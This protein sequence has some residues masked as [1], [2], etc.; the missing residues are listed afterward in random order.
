MPALE[1]APLQGH[2]LRRGLCGAR[3]E[4]LSGE[5]LSGRGLSRAKSVRWE[6]SWCVEG[7]ER[8]PV[9]LGGGAGE[10]KKDRRERDG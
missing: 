2:G 9:G 3:V 5:S 4:N 6:R 8:R 7:T 10:D 1:S